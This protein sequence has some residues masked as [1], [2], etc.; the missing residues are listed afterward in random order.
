MK[1]MRFGLTLLLVGAMMLSTV[2]AAMA[3]Q[4][5]KVGFLLAG[6]G[7]ER[8][9]KDRDYFIEA[10]KQHGFDVVFDVSQDD[11]K[12]QLDKTQNMIAQGI[13][14]LVILPVDSATAKTVVDI[15]HKYEVPVIA[16]DRNIYN[17]DVDV[18]ITQDSYQVGRLQAEA[19]AKWL[20]GKGNVVICAG[21]KGHSVAEEI[22]RGARE[23]IE[24]KYPNMKIV[25]IQYHPKWGA[26]EA[27]ATV[28]NA[29][30]R[31]PRIDAILCNNSLM[32]RGVV[33]A[34]QA[35]GLTGKI[36]VAGADADLANCQYI[37]KGLQQYEV[38]KDIKPLAYKAAEIAAAMV[39]GKPWKP[40]AYI[41]NGKKDVPVIFTPVYGFDKTN[42]DDVII[43]SGFH[44]KEDVYGK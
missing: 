15:A 40:D 32:A 30:T 7:V 17:S 26:E 41:N 42:I 44:K 6:F 35:E 33:Q 39:F 14:A 2:G 18:Y 25:L 20:G 8:F 37:V 34:L 36:F 11:D 1:S 13:K 5:P 12:I 27:M 43:K 3:A 23:T 4:A 10:A 22:T 16:Y 29:L 24:K 38:L 28:E 9:Y 31:F 21:T 19:A